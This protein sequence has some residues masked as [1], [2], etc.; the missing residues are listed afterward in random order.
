MITA[1]QLR[2]KWNG[3]DRWLSDGGA[4]NMGRLVRDSDVRE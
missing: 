3:R 2:A 4:Q 1:N